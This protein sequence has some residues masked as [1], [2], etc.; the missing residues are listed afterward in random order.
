MASSWEDHPKSDPFLPINALRW[1]K[2]HVAQKSGLPIYMSAIAR[3]LNLS[4]SSHTN[5][6]TY[7]SNN[8]KI[9]APFI[10]PMLNQKELWF[11]R[12]RETVQYIFLR[13]LQGYVP[14]RQ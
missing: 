5:C 7:H 12:K 4:A 11:K 1:Q 6:P 8:P 3:L 14:I 10:L 9:L 13:I 2:N